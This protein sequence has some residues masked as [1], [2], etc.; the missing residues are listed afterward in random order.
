MWFHANAK[1][2]RFGS[3]PLIA[4]STCMLIASAAGLSLVNAGNPMGNSDI[5]SVHTAAVLDHP[6]GDRDSRTQPST[7]DHHHHHKNIIVSTIPQQQ[8]D[9]DHFPLKDKVPAD[10]PLQPLNVLI[11]DQTQSF[12]HSPDVIIQQQYLPRHAHY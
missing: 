9:F 7:I 3:S 1:A 8:Q 5:H 10:S 6:L 4:L 2:L 12:P 11:P